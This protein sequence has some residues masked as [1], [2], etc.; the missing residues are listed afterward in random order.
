MP[1]DKFV[2]QYKK[3]LL[4]RFCFIF[5]EA[6]VY[7]LRKLGKGPD[8]PQI[9]F[10]CH[11]ITGSTAN[12]TNI[13][14]SDLDVIVLLKSGNSVFKDKK[15]GEI[16]GWFDDHGKEVTGG[17]QSRLVDAI[18]D[19]IKYVEEQSIVDCE[20][21]LLNQNT[22]GKCIFTFQLDL[23]RFD[24]LFA[25]KGIGSYGIIGHDGISKSTNLLATVTLS[26]CAQELTGF[27]EMTCLLKWIG[28]KWRKVNPQFY[29][30]SCGF[31]SVMVKIWDLPDQRKAWT[32]T[33]FDA[34]FLGCLQHISDC[35]TYNDPIH[36]GN[37]GS[38][39]IMDSFDTST[40]PNNHVKRSELIAFLNHWLHPSVP[41]MSLIERLKALDGPLPN[42]TS[43][44]PVQV[45][46]I[47]MVNPISDDLCTS[48]DEDVKPVKKKKML[49]AYHYQASSGD[50]RE[51]ALPKKP[52]K[53][54]SQ[55]KTTTKLPGDG[56]KY[57][58][59]M[60]LLDAFY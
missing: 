14:L 27:T 19:A 7:E 51:D 47:G 17:H 53:V 56:S 23:L 36:P 44:A 33:R 26:G 32:K 38:T 5:N 30:P 8:W 57:V 11:T 40:D 4:D 29:F 6:L 52:R 37:E 48:S 58:L 60:L 28:Y 15:K 39:N 16:F 55:P 46:N 20:F 31:E 25:L 1:E 59:A 18:K 21:K 22:K 12:G 41:Q 35:L 24:L 43:P 45:S 34:I 49:N 10:D 3:D 2:E 42:P 50:S 54:A 13:D 9:D